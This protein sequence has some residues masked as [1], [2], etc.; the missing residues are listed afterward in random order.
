MKKL[1]KEV[2]QSKF[3]YYKPDEDLLLTIIDFDNVFEDITWN[4]NEIEIEVLA[5][6]SHKH[7]TF[8]E[9]ADELGYSKTY[10]YLSY[11]QAIN[12]IVNNIK[13]F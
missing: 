11:Q 7:D 8:Q 10:I 6:Y 5:L 12:K 3:N 9:I 2:L 1:I 4:L 13:S